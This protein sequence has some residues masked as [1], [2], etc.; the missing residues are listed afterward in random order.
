MLRDRK[1]ELKEV[2]R[3]LAGRHNKQAAQR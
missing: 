3:E 2:W 1:I